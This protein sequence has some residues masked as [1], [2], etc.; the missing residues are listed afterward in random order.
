MLILY[1]LWVTFSFV[2]AVFIVTYLVAAKL[3]KRKYYVLWAIAFCILTTLVATGIYRLVVSLT[4]IDELFRTFLLACNCLIVFVL[5]TLSLMFSHM[6][7][8]WEVL[9]CATAGYSMQHITQRIVECLSVLFPDMDRLTNA[10]ILIFITLVFYFWMYFFV[11]RKANMKQ[12]STD[13]KVQVVVSGTTLIGS[14][15]IEGDKVSLVGPDGEYSNLIKVNGQSLNYT[16]MALKN[17]FSEFTLGTIQLKEGLNV[18]EIVVNNESGAMGGTYKA[19]GFMTDYL[20][21]ADYGD[22]SF[23]WSP[24][25]DNLEVV[26]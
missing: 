16:P 9:F 2:G 5:V 3:P 7:G 14:F 1:N 4:G 20:R 12:I 8:L 24:I 17:E 19:V 15:A 21:L 13:A 25:Y 11:L 6:C 18:I 22:A 10:I 26:K 23:T